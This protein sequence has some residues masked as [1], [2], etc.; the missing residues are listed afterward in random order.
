M[1]SGLST[2]QDELQMLQKE[3]MRINKDKSGTI[4]IHELQTMTRGEVHEM[5]DIDWAKVIKECDQSGD[6]VIDFQEFITAC[7]SR[8]AITNKDTIKAAFKI[9]D[10]NKDGQISLDDF[11][12]IFCSYGGA[13]MN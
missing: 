9:L 11:D 12:A 5:Y 3:F 8:K 6:G 2:T 13:K 4:N 1:I 10:T 7:I